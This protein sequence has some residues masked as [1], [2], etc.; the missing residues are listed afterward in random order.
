MWAQEA[1]RRSRY[2]PDG[3]FYRRG[4]SRNVT[5]PEAKNL[6]AA[7]TNCAPYPEGVPRRRGTCWR[8]YGV[9]SEGIPTGIGV[10]VYRD[11]LGGVVV[12][13]TI[14]DES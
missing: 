8:I 3:H 12:L 14:L 13:I 10:E 2:W 6:I 11:H 9:D 5:I 1:I 7:A 4:A